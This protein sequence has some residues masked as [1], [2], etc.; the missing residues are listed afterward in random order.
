MHKHWTD[1]ASFSDFIIS[2]LLSCS[3]L[4]IQKQ[5]L[6]ELVQKKRGL[7][8]ELFNN[9]L[10]RLRTKGILDSYSKKDVVINK[11]ALKAHTLFAKIK[12]KPTGNTKVM[13]LY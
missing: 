9:N 1:E 2:H 12:T 6:Y 5:V 3:S 7:N 13:V 11:N 8:K 10:Y 4:R